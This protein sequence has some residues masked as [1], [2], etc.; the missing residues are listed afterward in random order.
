MTPI[1][2]PT[3]RPHSRRRWVARLAIGLL[4]LFAIGDIWVRRGNW[5]FEDVRAYWE[6]A[7]RVREG[8]PLYGGTD[9]PNSYGVFRYAPWFAWM[10]IPLTYLPRHAAELL[11]GAVLAAASLGVLVALLRLRSAA[12]VALA[13]LLLP[14]FMSLVQVGNVQPRLVAVLA[15]GVSRRSGP[16]WIALAASIKATPIIYVLIYVAR[17][18]WTR[19]ALAL[20]ITA[21]LLAPLLLANVSSY[22]TNPGAS[23]SLYYYFGPVAWAVAAG[24]SV[25]LAAW[26]AWRRSDW[27]WVA[28]SVAVALCAPRAHVTY[29][30]FLA[31]GLLDGARDRIERRT[32]GAASRAPVSRDSSVEE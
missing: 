2:E 11:W 29:A 12:A 16:L 5:G 7:L 21:M 28:A 22:E 26:L 20:L 25:L 6:A 23:F 18:Q 31:V 30:T 10:W 19:V 15:F 1:V 24:T 8:L 14:M 3:A 32:L 27:V 13:V 9:D 4:L 17:R